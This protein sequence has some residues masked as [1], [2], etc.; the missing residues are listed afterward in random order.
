MEIRIPRWLLLVPIVL[1]ALAALALAARGAIAR[2]EDPDVAVARRAAVQIQALRRDETYDALAPELAD[3]FR[4]LDRRAPESERDR[5]VEVLGAALLWRGEEN[6]QRFSEVAVAIKVYSN[7][8][9][10]A[11]LIDRAVYRV[12]GGRVVLVL[13]VKITP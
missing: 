4:K 2:G 10:G 11:F 13:P 3:H 9:P 7:R 1:V 12:Q 6:G 5:R 8:N